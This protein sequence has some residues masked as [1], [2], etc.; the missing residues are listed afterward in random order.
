[1]GDNP[2]GG[3]QRGHA[4][5][6]LLEIRLMLNSVSEIFRKEMYGRKYMTGAAQAAKKQIPQAA[7]NGIANEQRTRQDGDRDG[8]A[9]NNGQIGSPVVEET[10]SN[11]RGRSHVI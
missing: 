11:Q 7:T 4:L 1:M 6:S 10:S 8:H 9:S 2:L 3:N 5:K